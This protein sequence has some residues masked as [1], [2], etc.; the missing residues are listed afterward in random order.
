MT[1]A[2]GKAV[3]NEGEVKKNTTITIKAE[4]AAGYT[5]K[6]LTANGKELKPEYNATTHTVPFAVQEEDVTIAVGFEKSA[7]TPS[8]EEVEVTLTVTGEL[9]G[10]VK[11]GE[12]E[13]VSGVNKVKKGETLKVTAKANDGFQLKTFTID[14]VDRLAEAETGIAIAFK[15]AVAIAVEFKTIPEGGDEKVTLKIVQP[16]DGAIVVKA[17]DGKVLENGAKIE[18][19]TITITATP[20]AQYELE[21]LKANNEDLTTK[22]DKKTH[23]VQ[24]EVKAD[25]TIRAKFK[26]R[27]GGDRPT[28]PIAPPSTGVEDALFANVMVAP[29]PFTNQLRILNPEGVVGRYTLVNTLGGVVRSGA[30]SSTEVFVDTEALPAGI[31]FVCIEIQGGVKR[32]IMAI[33]H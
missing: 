17:S 24:Y 7:P 23:S 9:N 16:Q 13:L 6:S 29:N 26:K 3:A 11:V 14:G 4:P 12:K 30:L 19:G 15:Q 8:E 32:S 33:K 28:P 31:Y 21:W 27:N 18:K 25:V 1:D 2:D 10:K 20:S 5:L 22:V